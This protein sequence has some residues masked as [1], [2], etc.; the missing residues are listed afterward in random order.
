MATAIVRLRMCTNGTLPATASRNRSKFLS[1]RTGVETNRNGRTHKTRGMGT[2]GQK[3]LRAFRTY[4]KLVM[5]PTM[6][7]NIKITLEPMT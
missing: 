4:I 3:G 5:K 1:M 6:I 7:A 2:K